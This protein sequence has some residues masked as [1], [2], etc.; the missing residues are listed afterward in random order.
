[1]IH[2]KHTNKFCKDDISLIENYDK[3]VTDTTQMWD[4]HHRDE[5]RI[6]PS[7]MI[8][9]RSLAELK[10][11]GR[12][13]NCP[14]NELIFLTRS[15]H[16]KLHSKYKSIETRRK[17]SESFKGKNNPIYG[18]HRSEE[19][20]RKISEAH[21]GKTASEETKRKMSAVRKGKKF[22]AEH[23]RKLS[24]ARKAYLAKRMN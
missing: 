24:E 1:M 18:K 21:K 7:G 3:A 10:E 5:I 14:A 15:E 16:M 23:K 13:Y 20:K 4:C 11:N 19:T 6:L 22:S 2:L 12:Y 17:M 8:V 9:I